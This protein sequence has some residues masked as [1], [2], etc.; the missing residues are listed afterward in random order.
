METWQRNHDLSDSGIQDMPFFQTVL[1]E[2]TVTSNWGHNRRL[3]KIQAIPSQSQSILCQVDLWTNNFRYCGDILTQLR[4]KVDG[5]VIN[6]WAYKLWLHD[7]IMALAWFYTECF[8]GAQPHLLSYMESTAA[9]QW[10]DPVVV[11]EDAWSVKTKIVMIWTFTENLLV[12]DM[13]KYF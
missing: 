13:D 8:A 7:Q 2:Q 6:N 4:H 5:G 1:G 9:F 11:T 10:Q 12:D 3:E